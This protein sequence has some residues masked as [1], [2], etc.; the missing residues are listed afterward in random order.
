VELVEA[1]VSTVENGSERE[2][3]LALENLH[4]LSV[5][6]SEKYK[7]MISEFALSTL[8]EKMLHGTNSESENAAAILCNLSIVPK[9][10]NDI[11]ESGGTRASVRLAQTGNEIQREKAAFVLYQLSDEL[12]YLRTIVSQNGLDTLV[13]MIEHCTLRGKSDAAK[14]LFDISKHVEFKDAVAKAEGFQALIDYYVKLARDGTHKEKELAA[15]SLS[16]ITEDVGCRLM[17]FHSNGVKPL[18]N[19]VKA[20]SNIARE[21]ALDTLHHLSL[22]SE[23]KHQ[24]KDLGGVEILIDLVGNGSMKQ[25]DKAKGSLLQLTNNFDG[26]T[27][28]LGPPF[29]REEDDVAPDSNVCEVEIG[30]RKPRKKIEMIHRTRQGECVFDEA[31]DQDYPETEVGR[32]LK[33][34]RLEK[35]AFEFNRYGYETK[36]QVATR[37]TNDDL[38]NLLGVKI[39]GDRNLL[40]RLFR[41]KD[42]IIQDDPCPSLQ[43][44][45]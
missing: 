6:A 24:M 4:L 14:V 37:M 17:V 26:S 30:A 44:E 15:E 43:I 35:Y 2:R 40:K 18:I 45:I 10:R 33:G 20:G 7:T 1:I 41:I 28:A 36:E 38:K 11:H 9:L 23:I 3:H 32:L 34:S 21:H 31:N 16:R 22:N 42:E 13:D 25:K 8:V 29:V 12:T 5:I 27:S 19:I 39:A